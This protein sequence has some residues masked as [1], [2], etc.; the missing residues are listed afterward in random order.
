MLFRD[1]LRPLTQLVA[2]LAQLEDA[3]VPDFPR[4]VWIEPSYSWT[5]FR[6]TDP[7]YAE[8]NCDHPPGDLLRGQALIQYVYDA[9]RNSKVWARSALV[10][11]YD[12]HG[13][14]YDHVTPP[15]CVPSADGFATRGPRVPAIVVS[16][17]VER[18]SVCRPPEGKVFDH[19]SV[20]KFLCEQHG[21]EPW[22]TRLWD[23]STMSLSA[24]FTSPCRGASPDSR[25]MLKDHPDLRIDRRTA[26][27]PTQ[28]LESEG[29]GLLSR[30]F[31]SLCSLF[32]ELP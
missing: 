9:L 11:Y 30:A 16:P 3:D 8:P 19:C 17:F 2:D 27:A 20:L 14:F 5:E 4:L 23:D 21:I 32:D 31:R 1:R 7:F 6:A 24:F 12:E 26:R 29:M 25:L 18:G 15:A 22:T 10:I 13:G 28:S